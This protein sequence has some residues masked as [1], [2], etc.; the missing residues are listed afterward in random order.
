[1]HPMLLRVRASFK[2]GYTD[3]IGTPSEVLV[4]LVGWFELVV[5][6]SCLE[7]LTQPLHDCWNFLA[8]MEKNGKECKGACYGWL[9]PHFSSLLSHINFFDNCT[10]A[11]RVP[12]K[13]QSWA[14]Y[15]RDLKNLLAHLSTDVQRTPSTAVHQPQATHLIWS[16]VLNK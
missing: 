12:P 10:T 5:D 4:E 13:V 3:L 16:R 9:S 8:R 7:R 6:K 14:K 1:M 11:C 2:A 15:R